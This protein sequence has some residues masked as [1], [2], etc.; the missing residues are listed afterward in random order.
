MPGLKLALRELDLPGIGL[1]RKQES[2]YAQI[3]IWFA[4]QAQQLRGIASPLRE[5]VF[6]GDTAFNDGRAYA[7]MREVSGWQASCFIGSERLQQEPSAE[8]D[9][10]EGF[11]VANR[12][13]AISE[14]VGWMLT[15]GMQ[16]DERSAVIVDIDKTAI[17]AKGRNDQVIDE[18]RLEGAYS[19]M[20][21]LL[22]EDVPW[23]EF[24][25]Y[26]T[27]L[28]R[29]RY[30]NVTADN[31]DYLAYMCL[32]LSTGLISYDEVE[33]EVEDGSLDNF[34]QFTR[35][36]ESRMMI[37]SIAGEAFRQAHDAVMMGV[38]NGDPT[39]FKRFRRQEFVSTIKRMGQLLDDSP[40][41]TLL[42]EEI[43]LTQ[44][45]CELSEWL[46]DRG[47]LIICLSDKPDEASCPDPRI[48]PDLQPVH[49]AETHRV[50][51]SIRP[52]LDTLG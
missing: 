16:L 9:Q 35:W 24:E 40:V 23:S 44:E 6:V 8:L 34:D 10:E 38:R 45:V 43:T 14:W 2:A 22:G 51:S 31:Q 39:P 47:C 7:N 29:S 25:R 11:F 1:P 13:Q 28:N 32:V 42:S 46:H 21:T 27:G 36:V 26:Y 30:H 41:E 3:A 4:T 49:R 52:I 48:T 5:L 37:N 17:G 19:A 18:A 12:W 33:R 20:S 50:G 15:R